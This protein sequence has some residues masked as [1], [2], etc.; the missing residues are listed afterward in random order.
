[1]LMPTV[2]RSVMSRNA[3]A[4]VAADRKALLPDSKCNKEC[5][6]IHYERK[7]FKDTE[8]DALVLTGA[9]KDGP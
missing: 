9:I 4:F 8:V 7:S 5:K 6:I 2:E 3:V 1:M